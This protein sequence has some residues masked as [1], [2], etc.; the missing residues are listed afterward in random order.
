[1]LYPFLFFVKYVFKKIQ[2]ILGQMAYNVSVVYDVF[3]V[4]IKKRE[5]FQQ[6]Q[7]CAGI[8]RGRRSRPSRMEAEGL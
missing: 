1:M 4:A 3:A 2:I 6:P 8:R 5:A 7:K